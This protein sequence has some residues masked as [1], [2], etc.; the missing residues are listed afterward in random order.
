[1]FDRQRP[2]RLRRAAGLYTRRSL[3][4]R[5][6]SSGLCPGCLDCAF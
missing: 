2:A 6:P 4:E 1:M 3:G 5:R